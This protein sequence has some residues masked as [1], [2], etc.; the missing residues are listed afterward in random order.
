M[1]GVRLASAVGEHLLADT[2][3]AELTHTNARQT[4]SI[5]TLHVRSIATGMS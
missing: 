3:E 1:R 5:A 2:I 4:S